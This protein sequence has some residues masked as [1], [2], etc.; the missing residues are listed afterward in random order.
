MKI[1]EFLL[2]LGVIVLLSAAIAL[3]CNYLSTS[4]LPVF[5]KYKPD[6][7]KET[8]VDLSVY[9]D[10]VD[11]ETLKSLMEADMVVLLDA[12]TTD[13]FKKGHLPKAIS[14]PIL[15]FNEKYEKAAGLLVEDKS[16]ITYCISV[17][18]IDSSMLA[19]ELYQRGHREIYVYKGGIEEWQALGNPVEKP[20][21][22][23]GID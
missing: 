4:P 22:G 5:K 1:K 16:I 12:R 7:E 8:G 19:K 13:N 21:E 14:L 17:H 9:Y 2:Q 10:E 3:G 6:P 20:A 18:C 23:E 11:V 15:E